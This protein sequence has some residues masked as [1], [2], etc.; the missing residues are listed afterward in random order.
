MGADHATSASTGIAARL[1]GCKFWD[2]D[3]TQSS[4]LH[5][6]TDIP[7]EMYYETLDGE[8]KNAGDPYYGAPGSQDMTF[9]VYSGRFSIANATHL[10]NMIK[11]TIGYSES[12]VADEVKNLFLAGNWLWINNGVNCTGGDNVEEHVGTCT[13]NGYT[14]IGFP[15]NDWNIER[16]YEESADEWDVYDIRSGLKSHKPAFLIHDGHG[17][18]SYVWCETSTGVREANYPQN[19][20]DKGNYFVA[21]T[22]ACLPGRFTIGQCIMEAFERLSTGIVASISNTKSGWGDNDGTDGCTHRPFRYLID[23]LFNPEH[24]MHH[25]GRLHARGKEANADIVLNTDLNTPPYYY[26]IVYCIYET[27]LLGDPALSIWTDTPI[28]MSDPGYPTPLTGPNFTWNSGYNYAWMALVDAK[29]GEIVYTQQAD[30]DGKFEINSQNNKALAD[31]IAAN[32]DVDF[33]IRIKAQNYLPFEGDLPYNP[34]T[35]DT[36]GQYSFV[37][38][39]NYYGKKAEIRYELPAASLVNIAVYNAKGSIV[40]NVINECKNAGQHSATFTTNN[41]PNGVYY[42]R[43]DYNNN[44]AIDKF[45]VTK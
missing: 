15:E 1:F 4:N 2:H 41:F 9:E 17:N 40:K 28:E 11:K 3:Q 36:K 25:L 20:A 12:P 10:A 14:T 39:I 13:A 8:W 43:I 34:T 5:E 27:V 24:K 26:C 44:T 38:S 37:N 6:E 30:K 21:I 45:V 32:P 29:S 33:K 19:S 18:E 31:Y 16:L 23:G 7:S 42:C 22:G 35:I